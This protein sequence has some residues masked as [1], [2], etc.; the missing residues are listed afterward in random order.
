MNQIED[1]YNYSLRES[2]TSFNY[3]LTKKQG[4][5]FFIIL[6]LQLRE[7]IFSSVG[8]STEYSTIWSTDGVA[9]FP[10]YF[11]WSLDM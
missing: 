8:V 6:N 10:I 4:K 2:K 5:S 7:I 1:Q 9:N 3:R 11:S